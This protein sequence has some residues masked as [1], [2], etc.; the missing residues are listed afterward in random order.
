MKNFDELLKPIKL[1]YGSV[2]GVLFWWKT[3]FKKTFEWKE[4]KLT[5]HLKKH[6]PRPRT[7]PKLIRWKRYDG[8]VGNLYGVKFNKNKK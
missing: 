2:F 5:I 4:W 6:E 3:K 8:E 1:S 7:F